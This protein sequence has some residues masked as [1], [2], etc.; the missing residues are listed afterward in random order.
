MTSA[1]VKTCITSLKGQWGSLSSN[2]TQGMEVFI[3]HGRGI[4]AAH[5]P[6]SRLLG[7][8]LPY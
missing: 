2:N 3:M 6:I 5:S 8:F 4:T 1:D 7:L